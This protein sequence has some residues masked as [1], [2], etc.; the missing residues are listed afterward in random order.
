MRPACAIRHPSLVC[1]PRLA[2]LLLL[3]C[4]S[5]CGRDAHHATAA[6]FSARTTAGTTFR[7]SD[8][9][10]REVVILAFFAT[11]SKPSLAEMAHLQ[12]LYEA[13][14]GRGLLIVAVSVDGPETASGVPGF[15][16]RNGLTFPV[17]VDEDSRI[18]SL[19][20]P[21]RDVPFTVVVDRQ[22][23]TSQHE[24]YNPGD[25]DLIAASAR[26]A[27]ERR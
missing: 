18:A 13:E 12:A 8:H 22:G 9:L 6:D 1:A 5:G 15:A 26:A 3:L 20:N 7:L 24:G 2:A 11:W 16:Y 21:R 23:R 10:G 17:V 4:A 19:Y 27:L 14:K 25:E